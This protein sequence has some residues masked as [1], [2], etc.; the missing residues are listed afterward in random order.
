MSC[1]SCRGRAFYR[2]YPPANFVI[3][4]PTLQNQQS[5]M[6]VGR[7]GDAPIGCPDEYS[8]ACALLAIRE[9]CWLRHE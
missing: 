7:V 3:R 8:G 5:H 1:K 9:V 4:D 6:R 2:I